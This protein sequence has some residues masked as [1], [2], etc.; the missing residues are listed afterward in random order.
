MKASFL[1]TAALL[2]ASTAFAASKSY[3]LSSPDGALT[4]TV[5]AG[6]VL[7]YSVSR[8]GTL[9]LSPSEIGLFLEDGRA[10]DASSKVRKVTRR[11]VDKTVAAPVYKKAQVRDHFQEMTLDFK[12]FQLVFRAY[13]EGVAYRIVPQVKR[14]FA[15]KK[16]QVQYAFPKDWKAYVPYVNR[17]PNSLEAQFH[18]SFESRYDVHPLSRWTDGRIAFMP[19]TVEAEDG[20]TLCITESD[21]VHYPGT[22]LRLA[23]DGKTMLEGLQAGLPTGEEEHFRTS[24]QGRE[25]V[26]ARFDA[27]GALPWRVLLVAPE[28]KDLID[29]DMPWVLAKEPAGDF[30]W[31]K[32]GKVA[33]DWWNNWNVYGVNFRAGINNET[34]KFYI[35]FAS[36]VGVEYVILDEG[37]A[38]DREKGLF[39]VI[40]E[41]DIK[42]L[43]DYGAKRNVG[44][45]L[46]AYFTLF[47]KDMEEV[48]RH[49]SA[50]GVKGFK[51]DFMDRDDQRMVD[52]YYR[53]A[54]TAAR[55]NLML[56]FHGAYKPTGLQRTWP[57][58][59]NFEGVYGLENMKW[60]NDGDQVTYDVQLPFLRNV[61]GP[62]D[63]T[64]GAMHNAGKDNY[65]AS[66]SQPM[67]QGTRC[68]QLAEYTI[69]TSPLN[70]LCDSPSNYLKELECAR[71]IAEVPT[72][73]DETVPLVGVIGEQVA[74]A[75][76][77]GS[78]WYVGALTG[79]NAR[80]M[81]IDLGFLDDGDWKME[82]FRDGVNA[83]RAAE[84]YVHETAAVPSD[85]KI[86]V[87]MAP[88]GGWT[89]R[90]TPS[91]L[92]G[93]NDAEENPVI[94][95][96]L[97]VGYPDEARDAK[98]R[99]AGK[100][101]YIEGE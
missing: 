13:D 57:N 59:I 42:E 36:K 53:A 24:I 84:D 80:E 20:V 71:F 5:E 32:P 30:S 22:Y 11:S 87:Q 62:M 91:A 51:V 45:I 68:R 96:I 100:I 17:D 48:C 99:D 54:E 6:G 40:P 82:I 55:Y 52:F 95:D 56:D 66:H 47:D 101:R 37:W 67:S 75:R 69:F 92:S 16:E 43:V 76:R 90:I 50:M 60:D 34:Y 10:L 81:E 25:D 72:V 23:K 78:V 86:T 97:A 12:D 2:A 61:A 33:W 89:A 44:I 19:I 28:A 79:W 64:Q 8:E 49:Y 1:F 63:Y 15:V 65:H 26:I 77:K 21:L 9:L 35:D 73:W 83:D 94:N 41:F 27:A 46:W 98:P 7:R 3:N 29:S 88:G 4:V 93:G 58:V 39:D 85:R 31:V 18:S 74:V 70:M 14:A 38:V